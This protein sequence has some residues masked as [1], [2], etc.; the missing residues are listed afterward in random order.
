MTAVRQIACAIGSFLPI[1]CQ[2]GLGG[3]ER[4][5]DKKFNALSRFLT[6]PD[7]CHSG[8]L[9]TNYRKTRRWPGP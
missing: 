3:T 6:P 5:I 8:Y 9:P 7:L 2:I 4:E 1:L